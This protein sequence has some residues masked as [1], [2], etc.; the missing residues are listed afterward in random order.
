MIP[1]L[2]GNGFYYHILTSKQKSIP[3]TG[4][5]PIIV[6][7]IELLPQPIPNMDR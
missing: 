7:L 3:F 6:Y 4:A 1:D 2:N 5:Y